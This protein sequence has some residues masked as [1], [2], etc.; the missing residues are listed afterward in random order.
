MVRRITI[1][2]VALKELR[3]KYLEGKSD[4]D[5]VEVVDMWENLKR[6]HGKADLDGLLDLMLELSERMKDLHLDLKRKPIEFYAKYKRLLHKYYDPCITTFKLAFAPNPYRPINQSE[7][8]ELSRAIQ[9]Y[10]KAHFKKV[11]STIVNKAVSFNLSGNVMCDHCGKTKNITYRDGKPFCYKLIKDLKGIKENTP[12]ENKPKPIRCHYCKAE[13]HVISDCPKLL[14]KKS[15]EDSGF[16]HLFIGNINS[17][18]AHDDSN[19]EFYLKS[20]IMYTDCY[21][22]NFITG[23]FVD[24]LADSS[25]SMHF[26]PSDRVGP[27]FKTA[28]M[29]NG[30]NCEIN[31]IRDVFIMDELG[32]EICLRNAHSVKGVE[33]RIISINALRKDGWKLIDNGNVKFTYL[34]KDNCRVTFI[35]KENN[36]HCLQATEV[37]V[38]VNNI[39]INTPGKRPAVLSKEAEVINNEDKN[40][41]IVPKVDSLLRIPS[42]LQK[43]NQAQKDI[44]I[45][46][47][48]FFMIHINL[49]HDLHGHDG[50][51]RM[52][53]KAKV[54]GIHLI[55]IL[56]CDACSTGNAKSAAIQRKTIILLKGRMNKCFWT[57]L[58]HSEF[59]LDKEVVYLIFS[60]LVVVINI[61]RKCSSALDQ[62]NQILFTCLKMLTMYVMVRTYQIKI[63]QWIMQVKIRQSKFFADTI[64]AGLN[65]LLLIHQN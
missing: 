5:F 29:A 64:I 3:N 57:Q 45:W 32:T 8:D 61:H 35:E 65:L 10:W 56:H 30:S 17:T 19:S 13:G 21:V 52:R 15:N 11:E 12:N 20:G 43:T 54:L 33:K 31:D 50:L 63:L 2:A 59:V 34:A 7:F 53:A 26:W 48:I 55:G 37:S 22:F 38:G 49:F 23:S 16:N 44:S 4:D 18:I 24:V 62:Q 6:I 39:A 9:A 60:C 58:V 36:L 47:L 40:E 41:I 27:V 51:S 28:K 25:A 42:T 14:K 1:P 46:T